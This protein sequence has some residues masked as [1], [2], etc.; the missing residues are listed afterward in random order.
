MDHNHKKDFHNFYMKWKRQSEKIESITLSIL[1]FLA[2]LNFEHLIIFEYIFQ[3]YI[4][5]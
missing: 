3:T 4:M 1:Y 5:N 2:I